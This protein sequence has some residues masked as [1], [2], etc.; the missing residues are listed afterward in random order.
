MKGMKLEDLIKEQERKDLEELAKALK[1]ADR[2]W[3]NIRISLERCG[4]IGEFNKEDFMVGVIEEDVIIREPLNSPTKSVSGYSPTF[5]P[6]Y[7]LR[8]LLVMDDKISDQGYQ[9]IEALYV[10]IEL[11]TKAVSRLGLDG[12]FAMGFG[13]GYGYVRTGWIAEKG[14]AIEREIFY[15]EFFRGT[16]INYNWDFFWNSVKENF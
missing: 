6:M 12:N 5:Y 15:K 10:F 14:W 16:T 11:A 4:D 2:E 7:F 1:I 9:S 13:S 3:E 8:N